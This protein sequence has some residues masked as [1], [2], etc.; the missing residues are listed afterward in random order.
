MNKKFYDYLVMLENAAPASK[1]ADFRAAR[2][3][4]AK[5]AQTE[6]IFDI[7][8]GGQGKKETLGQNTYGG[9]KGHDKGESSADMKKAKA[10]EA[11]AFKAAEKNFDKAGDSIIDLA[12][13][14]PGQVDAW[15]DAKLEPA[16]KKAITTDNAI[17]TAEEMKAG[18]ESDKKEWLKKYKEE[19]AA[20]KK[21]MDDEHE[22]S[23]EKAAYDKGV[24]DEIKQLDKFDDAEDKRAEV[25]K[26][27]TYD[28]W[29]NSMPLNMSKEEINP[30]VAQKKHENLVAKQ[31]NEKAEKNLKKFADD[32]DLGSDTGV[33]M[34]G[35]H[36]D[37]VEKNRKAEAEKRAADEKDFDEEYNRAFGNSDWAADFASVND[38][39]LRSVFESVYGDSSQFSDAEIRAICESCYRRSLAK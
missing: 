3:L 34:H 17:N 11:E 28:K 24:E 8:R 15:V 18:Y 29:D 6:G 30:T 2:E 39:G 19:E 14:K 9:S 1:K 33:P 37:Q 26:N 35:I 25:G 12:K 10:E 16:I 36:S 32:N 31:E 22:Y 20:A 38:K 13:H 21:A 5:K 7:F 4:Y 27:P 23:R